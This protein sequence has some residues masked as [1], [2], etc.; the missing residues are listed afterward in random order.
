MEAAL[1]HSRKRVFP[2]SF[3]LYPV[4]SSAPGTN[5]SGVTARGDF[6]IQPEPYVSFNTAAG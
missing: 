2:V 5:P 1:F 3:R 4:W 6:H